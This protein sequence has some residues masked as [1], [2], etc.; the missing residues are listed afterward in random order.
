MCQ[1]SAKQGCA[2][3]W[4]VI[5]LGQLAQ[6][7]AGLLIIE[8]AAVSAVGRITYGDLGLWDEHTEAALANT[9]KSVKKYSS[10]PMAIQLSH[11][12]RKASTEKPW[13]GGDLIK[14]DHENG[15]QVVGP[16]AIAFHEGQALPEQLTQDDINEVVEQ[17]VSSAKRAEKLGFDAIELHAA[18]GYL[19]HQ[20]LSPLS[21][22][23]D[24][25]YGGQL[26]NR[27]RFVLQVF[28]AVRE[29][30]SADM[31]VGIRISATDWV[32]N[33]WDISQ[34]IVLAKALDNQGCDYL[35]VSSG[36]L[37][38]L[39]DIPIAD[40]YQVPL[41]ESIKPHIKMPVIAVGLITRAEQAEAILQEDKAD[42]I[43]M[44]RGI[45]YNPH[46]AWQAAASLDATVE[47]PPQ[48]LRAEPHGKKG[49]LTATPQK[50]N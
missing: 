7:G 44:A 22:Q 34:S 1:Y 35:H 14:S 12:G 30:V 10:I 3:D 9:L 17:F 25:H 11:A 40:G 29:A 6:S 39:Q 18:H 50:E 32:D 20:F 43:A 49:H 37:S 41:A 24:D 8:A 31:V 36:G 46:W 23:R 2:Q 26:E 16:S 28:Q 27:M 5:H 13:L 38:P 42:A 45:L 19:L 15:W 4:H 33:G 21:N 48:Y 47:V